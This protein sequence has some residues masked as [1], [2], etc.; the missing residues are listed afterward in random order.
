MTTG[1]R[2]GVTIL[3]MLIVMIV[4]SVLLGILLPAIGRF[5]TNA[6]TTQSL[7]NLRTH[8]QTFTMYTA[9]WSDT[10][11][12][13]TRPGEV[14][15]VGPPGRRVGARYFDA[16]LM[17]NLFLARDYYGGT[18][19]ESV[20]FPP[21]YPRGIRGWDASITPILTPYFYPCT[22]I[23]HPGFWNARSRTGPDQWART[24]ISDVAFPDRKCLIMA[25][26]PWTI[27]GVDALN[28]G[29]TIE[30]ALVDGSAARYARKSLLPGYLRGDGT[31]FEEGSVHIYR[32]PPLLHTID[33]VRGRD[34]R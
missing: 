2:R 24:L 17:W 11:P 16:Y 9:D 1:Q 27:Q 26:Y 5:R 25:S 4:L 22:F 33:G 8:A 20:F 29:P 18:G 3:E 14:S 34:L 15:F 19:T 6:S 28:G 32:W 23:A 12:L 7:A 30:M 10:W 21:G 31:W 13:F